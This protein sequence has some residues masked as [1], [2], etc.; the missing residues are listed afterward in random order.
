MLRLI[1]RRCMKI[2]LKWNFTLNYHR[3]NFSCNRYLLKTAQIFISSAAGNW[4]FIVIS[5]IDVTLFFVCLN[6]MWV[7]SFSW[8][9]LSLHYN[10]WLPV[11]ILLMDLKTFCWALAAFWVSWSYTQSV[12]LLGGGGGGQPV[13]RT[14]YTKQKKNKL[15]ALSPRANYTDRAT[16]A[17]RRSDCQLLRI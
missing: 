10:T 9:T 17:C 13:A 11:I 3:Q 14:L 5:V 7:E 6:K 1:S 12:G 2:L 16:A 4:Y 15:H 8:S